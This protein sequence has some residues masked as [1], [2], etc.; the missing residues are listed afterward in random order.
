[1]SQLIK[2]ELQALVLLSQVVLQSSKLGLVLRM[3]RS[4]SR[5][6]QAQHFTR[7][8]AVLECLPK[9]RGAADTQVVELMLRPHWLQAARRRRFPMHL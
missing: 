6:Q 4:P 9:P 1:M 5:P 7:N 2:E 3:A 8:H